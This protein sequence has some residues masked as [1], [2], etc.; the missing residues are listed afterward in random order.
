MLYIP[1]SSPPYNLR[2]GRRTGWRRVPPPKLGYLLHLSSPKSIGPKILF[3]IARFL[4]GALVFFIMP[5]T[6]HA[7]P[8]LESTRSAASPDVG[9]AFE[10][11]LALAANVVP[12]GGSA[13]AG[14]A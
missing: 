9:H 11:L 10:I 7:V 12:P 2:G 13:R 3:K 6:I 1:E 14:A 8:A 4:F 5:T